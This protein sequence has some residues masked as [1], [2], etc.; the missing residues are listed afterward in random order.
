VAVTP[1]DTADY[2]GGAVGTTIT[3][4]FTQPCITGTHPGARPPSPAT[5]DDS[6]L[7]KYRPLGAD[8]KYV[9]YPVTE[10]T[11]DGVGTDTITSAPSNHP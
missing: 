8:G 9:S 11:Y 2:T 1:T 7:I 6:T 5:A 10:T 3:V 4:G